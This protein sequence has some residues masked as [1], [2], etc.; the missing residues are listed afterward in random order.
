MEK[1]GFQFFFKKGEKW[2]EMKNVE[3][4]LGLRA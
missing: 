4:G 1:K 3:A 2:I